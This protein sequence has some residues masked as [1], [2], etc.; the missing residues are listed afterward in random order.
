MPTVTVNDTS[1]GYSI[2]PETNVDFLFSAFDSFGEEL[3]AT[4][5]I[6]GDLIAGEFVE[7][8]VTAQDDAGNVAVYTYN[9]AVISEEYYV[10]LFVDNVL[11]DTVV[12]GQNENTNY[13]LPTPS[14][15]K[16]PFTSWRDAS[17]NVYTN[18]T[19]ESIRNLTK[20]YTSLYAYSE[21]TAISTKKELSNITLDG[22]YVLLNDLDF[23]GEA[24]KPL[25][26]FT[27]IF[28]GNGHVISNIKISSSL[29]SDY[30]G[31]FQKNSGI[32]MNLGLE[33]IS[34]N[35]VVESSGGIARYAGIICGEN[36]GTIKQC[37]VTGNV[38][39]NTSS[40]S[41]T[42][43]N[44]YSY[45]GG[46]AARNSG[47][48]ENSYSLATIYAYT[49]HTDS[50]SSAMANGS[51][52]GGIVA[53]NTSTGI[54]RNCYSDGEITSESDNISNTYA[55]GIA[56]DNTGASYS[57]GGSIINCFTT[58]NLYSKC[59]NADNAYVGRIV[60]LNVNSNNY[61][62]MITNSYGTGDQI[63][64]LLSN[65]I[66]TNIPTNEC[67]LVLPEYDIGEKEFFVDVLKWDETIWNF[68]S[69]KNPTLK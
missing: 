66:T 24:W 10:E 56:A 36:T 64:E 52:A 2:T 22:K 33:N 61:S 51:Y 6:N 53:D 45:A 43:G 41:S 1:N 38:K 12:V 46:I 58:C 15:W 35:I 57:Q 47:T 50:S 9:Y 25:G 37:Y 13:V 20:Q 63:I 65:N 69:G 7:I 68:N 62:G 34:M 28:D 19:G 55:G 48:I 29:S 4:V 5:E 42:G 8:V 44:T 54:I 59:S 39:V 17:N 31:L 27:G 3:Y 32:I 40:H 11:W 23:E 26:T 30:F 18:S 60:A 21:Y 14:D 67:G 16:L 49:S